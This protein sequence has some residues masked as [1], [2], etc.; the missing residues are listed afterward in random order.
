MCQRVA[1]TAVA[2]ALTI[3]LPQRHLSFSPQIFPQSEYISSHIYTGNN[4]TGRLLH[5]AMN[6]LTQAKQKN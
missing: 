4:K 1:G 5:Y 6:Y 3:N 2:Q